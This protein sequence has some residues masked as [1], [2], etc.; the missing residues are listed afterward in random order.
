MHPRYPDSFD[1]GWLDDWPP[2]D[3]R[4]WK[5]YRTYYRAYMRSPQWKALRLEFLDSKDWVCEICGGGATQAHHLT[6]ERLGREDFEDL[7]AL[8]RICHNKQHGIE[9]PCGNPGNGLA[10]SLF[11]SPD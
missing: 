11:G 1:P 5:N 6:Y 4:K 2:Y 10:Q 7:Q 3:P 9:R 8:C